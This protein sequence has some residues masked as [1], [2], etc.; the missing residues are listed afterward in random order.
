MADWK[1]I[2]EDAA[3]QIGEAATAAGQGIRQAAGE[4]GKV[5][6]IGVGS[7]DLRTARTTYGLGQ[8]IR[9]VVGLRLEE[10]VAARRLIVTLRA[11]RSRS[12]RSSG[13]GPTTET[14]VVHDFSI[15]LA[16]EETYES[17]EHDFT[18][19]LPWQ[20]ESKV[21]VGGFLGDALKM[22]R[23]VQSMNAGR[24]RWRLTAT[25]EIPWRRNLSKSIDL[26]VREE[27]V[28]EDDPPPP[29][30][31]PPRSEPTRPSSGATGS[32]QRPSSG[33]TGSSQR[34]SSGA[35]G[36]SS[37]AGSSSSSSSS[38]Q[39][40]STGSHASTSQAQSARSQST[41]SQPS[42]SQAQSARS[43]STGSRSPSTGSHSTGSHSTGS[44]STGSHS[45]G[46]HSTD[47]HSTGSHSTG[48]QSTGSQSTDSHATGSRA[49]SPQP[50]PAAPTSEPV[51]PVPDP[52][53]LPGGWMMARSRT[54]GAVQG[55]GWVVIHHWAGPPVRPEVV[56]EVLA[57]H[58]DLDPEVLHL[59]GVMDG[60]ELV[61]GRPVTIRGDYASVRLARS[62]AAE[63]GGPLH[64]LGELFLHRRIGPSIEAEFVSR[65][66]DAVRVLEIPPLER[67]LD[68]S[69]DFSRRDGRNVIFGPVTVGYGDYFGITRADEIARWREPAAG[70]SVRRGYYDHN[71]H[72]YHARLRERQREHPGQVWWVV[73]GEDHGAIL[74]D[75][76]VLLR[77]SEMLALCLQGLERGALP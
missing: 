29:P 70:A 58:P 54:L 46:S 41:G 42:A 73:R 77:W 2:L 12:V 68:E 63:Q 34:P 71:A 11:T 47:S 24:L 31:P 56:R 10:P 4:A 64:N 48:S 76:P 50:E 1:K 9:G 19:D 25:L 5:V 26:N 74:S 43:Q 62:L 69:E 61:I 60:L 36:S 51:A 23:A 53:P 40:R 21:D 28:D 52:I 15:E 38:S 39:S 37:G 57:R 18:L 72:A 65:G 32:S 6:G 30:R 44:H 14:E 67:L 7:I 16:G 35:T 17:G 66:D 75:P 59:H 45:T 13:Q 8:T 22:A 20:I 49:S 33:A 55:Q 3:Q 27:A